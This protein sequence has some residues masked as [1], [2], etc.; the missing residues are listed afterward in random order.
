MIMH[1]Y[2]M[3]LLVLGCYLGILLGPYGV[4]MKPVRTQTNDDWKLEKDKDQIQVYSRRLPNS[5]L[6]ELRIECTMPGTQSQLV[7]LLS[8]INN[9]EN[10]IYKMKSAR[11][12]KR[13]SE[14]ELIYYGVSALPWPVSDRDMTVRLTFN[15]VPTSRMLYIKGVDVPDLIAPH[16][17]RVRVTNWLANWQVRQATSKQMQITYTVRFDPGGEIPAWLD[18]VA[19][20]ASAFQ[21]FTL[22]RESI[23]LPRYQ[24]KS[25]AFLQ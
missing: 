18:N 15:Y 5:K 9:Y 16:T 1:I 22:L 7:A 17:G 23:L 6:S 20:S 14:T 13:I 24:G 11:L 21:S 19:A 2:T 4:G 3:N 12:V 25:F 8:D 10:V